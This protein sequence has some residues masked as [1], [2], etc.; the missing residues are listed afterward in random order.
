MTPLQQTLYE[1]CLQQRAD[2]YLAENQKEYEENLA[3][4]QRALD[5]LE[6]AGDPWSDLA[7]RVEYG[8]AVSEAIEKEAAFLAGLSLG[9]ELARI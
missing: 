9:Q 1:F 6:Q 7:Q 8:L 4:A 3:M 2:Q 5:Q